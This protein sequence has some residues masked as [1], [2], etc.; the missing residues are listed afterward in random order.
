MT[1]LT[2]QQMRALADKLHLVFSDEP[3]FVLDD[4][5]EALRTAA[6][7]LEAVRAIVEQLSNATPRRLLEEAL[8]IARQESRDE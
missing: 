5:E 7:Q 4:A 2:P 8:G 3:T 1:A 6:D